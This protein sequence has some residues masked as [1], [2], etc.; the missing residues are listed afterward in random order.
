[1][2]Q[3]VAAFARNTVFANILLAL[4]FLSGGIATVSMVREAF[5]YFSLDIISVQVP[6]PGAD[7][8]EV[9]E[10]IC[11]KIEEARSRTRR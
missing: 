2:K 3:V 5:P 1:M 11:R 8:E 6:Y 7:P 10:G 4:I 9:E